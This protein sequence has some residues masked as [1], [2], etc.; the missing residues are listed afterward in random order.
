VCGAWAE[1][2]GKQGKPNA[3][4]ESMMISIQLLL[5]T[6]LSFRLASKVCPFAWLVD[7]AAI[8]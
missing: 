5:S 8:S 6:S 3:K 2:K 1:A 7:R 4:L